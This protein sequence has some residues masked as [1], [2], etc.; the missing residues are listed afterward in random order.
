MTFY[1]HSCFVYPSRKLLEGFAGESP[2]KKFKPFN[3]TMRFEVFLSKL[4][5]TWFK[6]DGSFGQNCARRSGSVKN[7]IIEQF[8]VYHHIT[9]KLKNELL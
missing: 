3:F 9:Y 6:W 7:K 1:L 8:V 2:K 4:T 5:I